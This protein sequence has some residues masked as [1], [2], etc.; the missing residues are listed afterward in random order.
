[1]RSVTIPEP[2]PPTSAGDGRYH[3]P[4]R[5]YNTSLGRWLRQ[6]PAG[7]LDGAN[8]Y[9]VDNSNPI[10]NLDPQGMAPQAAPAAKQPAMDPATKELVQA[11]KDPKIRQALADAWAKTN[12]PV[13]L[14]KK[15][16]HGGTIDRGPGGA[17]AANPC[18]PG[19]PGA[20]NMDVPI[21][22]NEIGNYHG[23]YDSDEEQDPA[24]ETHKRAIVGGED[25]S[26]YRPPSAGDIQEAKSRKGPGI[27]VDRYYTYI[28]QPDGTTW[29]FPHPA[30]A[31][32]DPTKVIAVGQP[33]ALLKETLPNLK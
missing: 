10:I 23:H 27:A 14:D 2:S 6:D 18:Q 25:N 11:L 15:A 31:A 17:V 4:H 3:T 7:Y 19:K 33:D 8:L 9:Q 16:E 29:G 21:R 1:M 30:V 5:E 20:G 24:K 13:P 12:P 32:P 26:D 28:Y 22:P